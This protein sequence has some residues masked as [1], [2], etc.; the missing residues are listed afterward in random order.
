M[1]IVSDKPCVAA[2]PS[3]VNDEI[4]AQTFSALVIPRVSPVSNE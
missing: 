2:A 3:D 4:N 1:Q